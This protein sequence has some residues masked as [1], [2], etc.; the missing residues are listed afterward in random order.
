MHCNSPI[1]LAVPNS[2]GRHNVDG[3]ACSVGEVRDGRGRTGSPSTAGAS[4][5]FLNRGRGGST[6]L[7]F[8]ST[9]CPPPGR[10]RGDAPISA[11]VLILALVAL[12]ARPALSKLKAHR[13]ATRANRRGR[14]LGSWPWWRTRGQLFWRGPS[15]FPPIGRRAV[16]TT[17][18][19]E[20]PTRPCP[21]QCSA[22]GLV[23]SLPLPRPRPIPL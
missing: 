5:N 23:L 20:L 14:R 6:T 1:N 2:H 10:R 7:S 19:L 8:R 16:R 12:F 21:G 13:L 17:V 22:R 9:P 11:D 18:V 15:V 3:L 4:R